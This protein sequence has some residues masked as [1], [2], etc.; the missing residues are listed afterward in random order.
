M[1]LLIVD[2]EELMQDLY[3]ARVSFMYLFNVVVKG[4]G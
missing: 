3:L 4:C 2:W 1:N